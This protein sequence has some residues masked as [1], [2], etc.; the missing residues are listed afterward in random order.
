MTKIK[1]CGL[2]R[3]C[4]IA[5]AN[6]LRPDYIGFVF[7]KKSRRCVSSETAAALRSNL[8]RAI[9]PVGVFVNEPPENIARLLNDG[10]IEMAQ[11]H[12]QE[13]ETYIQTLRGYTKKP[14]IKAFSIRRAADAAAAALS[15]ADYILL[16]NGSGGTGKAF[17]WSLTSG[18]A[19]SYFLAGGLSA[20]N[21]AQA[22]D[23]AHPY[24][25]DVSSGVESDKVKNPEKM[26]RFILAVRKE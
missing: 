17:D 12:G 26:R 3:P 20:D 9:C 18:V 13:D 10:T 22:I 4:D 23:K 1:I 16:D 14:L 15:S 24:A 2:R 6:E 5:Y 8:D 19:R 25:V 21:V 7:A 11:L